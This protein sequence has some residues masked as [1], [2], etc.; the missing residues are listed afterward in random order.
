[1]G[2][3]FDIIFEWHL[4]FVQ[5]GIFYMT[6]FIHRNKR[7]SHILLEFYHIL[8]CR[9]LRHNLVLMGSIYRLHS[10]ECPKYHYIVLVHHMVLQFGIKFELDLLFVPLGI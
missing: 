3:L 5:L 2:Q 7:G 10:V 8:I 1:M 6:R 9:L 4:L